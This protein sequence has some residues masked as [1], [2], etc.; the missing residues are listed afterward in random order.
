MIHESF[1]YFNTP[2]ETWSILKYYDYRKR[3][4]SFAGKFRIENSRL[5]A[6]LERII[7]NFDKK[8]SKEQSRNAKRLLNRLKVGIRVRD[9]MLLGLLH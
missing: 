1:G 9:H 6:N 5:K 4:R 8:F 7:N 2:S 3:Q